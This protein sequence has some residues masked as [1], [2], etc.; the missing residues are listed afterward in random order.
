MPA[1]RSLTGGFDR[2]GFGWAAGSA[3]LHGAYVLC[4]ARAY[5]SGDLSLVYPV[6]RGLAPVLSTLAGTFVLGEVLSGANAAAVAIVAA[7]VYV[8]SSPGLSLADLRRPLQSLRRADGRWALLTSACIAAYS[9]W[10][11]SA[12]ASVPAWSL[13]WA[14]NAGNLLVLTPLAW[15]GVRAEWRRG[16]APL[17]ATGVASSLGYVLFL[18]AMS[19]TPLVRIAAAREVGIV[20]A[21]ALGVLVLREPH[22]RARIAGATVIAAGVAVLVLVR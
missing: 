2:A 14:G 6:S 8:A 16:P 7:G 18:L 1:W 20:A 12:V 17:L 5:S 9:A 22:G 15:R 21:A 10:D 13:N 19:M 3:A 4:L 11:K